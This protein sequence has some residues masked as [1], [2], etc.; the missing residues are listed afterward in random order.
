[1]ASTPVTL[2]A[3]RAAAS[4][5]ETVAPFALRQRALRGKEDRARMAERLGR[6]NLSRPDGQLVWIHGA[7]LG[8]CMAVLP[9]IGKLLETPGRSVLMTSV[10]VTSAGLM[11]ERLPPGAFHQ[12]APVDTPASVARFLDHWRP[13]IGLFVDSEIWPNTLA[14]AKAR[15]IPLALINGRM[16]ARSFAGW[17]YAPRTAAAI[18]SLYDLCL[19]IDDETA[20]RLRILGATQVQIGGS[21]K[22]DARPLPADA[23]KLA[24]LRRAV[25]GR[26]ILLASSTHAG[27]DET[28]LPAHDALRDAHP[29]LLTIVVP[30]HPERGADIAM[31]C[32]TRAVARRSQ[33][34][35]PDDATAIYIADTIGELGL[36][37]RIAPFAFV[38]GSLT[39][40]GGHN[41]LE[42]ALL[43]CGV[44]AGPHTANFT[45]AYNAI[46]AAQGAGRVTSCAEIAAL[47]GRLLNDPGDAKA[48]GDAAARGAASLGGAEERTRL[49]IES[50]LASHA[51]A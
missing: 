39:L 16:S 32:G 46:F 38:G 17:R 21:L 29:N 23:E 4:A 51:R 18:L 50:L 47:A 25:D 27:E 5:L 31:L 7:S 20:E 8:E 42:P 14:G 30:R 49:A 2:R 40:Q 48:L 10:T 11:T 28:I 15:G 41:P 3:Y 1:M 45:Q 22:A 6:T 24:Q 13:D 44:L 26:P 43:N 36:F 37:Y 12:Y 35:E 34:R 19:A 9:L 33:G